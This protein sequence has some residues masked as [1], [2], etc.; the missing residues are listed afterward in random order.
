MFVLNLFMLTNMC[1]FVSG[2][3]YVTVEHEEG[4]KIENAVYGLNNCFLKAAG[5]A[6]V[7]K[8]TLQSHRAQSDTLRQFYYVC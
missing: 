2:T 8:L 3:I 5:L 4:V 1:F 7:W 6:Q